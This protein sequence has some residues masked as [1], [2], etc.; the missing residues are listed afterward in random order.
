MISYPQFLLCVCLALFGAGV[1]GTYIVKRKQFPAIL[2]ITLFILLVAFVSCVSMACGVSATIPQTETPASPSAPIKTDFIFAPEPTDT[3][4]TVTVT[5][6]LLYV[7]SCASTACNVL[8][9]TKKGTHLRLVADGVKSDDPRCS[10]WAEIEIA[11][12]G[13]FVCREFVK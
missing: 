6:E 9:Y 7:R 8:V 11:G 4:Q 3:V 13:G 1:I 10:V 12:V 2:P 5:A